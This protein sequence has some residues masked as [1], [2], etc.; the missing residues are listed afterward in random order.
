MWK[1]RRS[2][3]S[4][5]LEKVIRRIISGFLSISPQLTPWTPLAPI[6]CRSRIPSRTASVLAPYTG[7]SGDRRCPCKVM[8]ALCWNG[9]ASVPICKGHLSSRKLKFNIHN[10]NH[11]KV[12]FSF[13]SLS[14]IICSLVSSFFQKIILKF[15]SQAN[16]LYQTFGKYT[17]WFH[18]HFR[19][20]F[21]P[22]VF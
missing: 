18:P 3:A 2:R 4:F 11:S 9:E 17:D 21:F 12:M 10:S 13:S 7:S 15:S 19:A 14:R 5:H 8:T 1:D 22:A 16:T 6:P 20:N